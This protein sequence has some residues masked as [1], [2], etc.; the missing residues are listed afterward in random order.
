MRRELRTAR[1]L[2]RPPRPGDEQAVFA[3]WMQDVE[4]L[5]YLG[6]RPHTS[7]AQTKALLD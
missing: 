1:L 4:V 5:R 2:L 3:A 7:V 6:M